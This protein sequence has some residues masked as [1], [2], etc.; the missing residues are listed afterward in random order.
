MALPE[1]ILVMAAGQNELHTS[2]GVAL[3]RW[4]GKK[5]PSHRRTQ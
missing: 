5:R 1:K 2:A 3:V 4:I